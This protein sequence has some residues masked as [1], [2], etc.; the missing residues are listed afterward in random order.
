MLAVFAL[1]LPS[2]A[3]ADTSSVFNINGLLDQGTISGTLSIDPTTGTVTGENF[4]AD[5]YAFTNADL[6]LQGIYDVDQGEQPVYYATLLN[7][8]DIAFKFFFTDATLIGYQGG[9][10][11]TSNDPCQGS[12]ASFFGIGNGQDFLNTGSLQLAVAPSTSV[13]PEPSA[14]LLLGTGLL[15]GT[16]AVRRRRRA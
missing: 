6:S 9:L 2:V 3:L 8:D 4:V 1:A 11:C 15:A 12:E 13:T 10:L 7:P 16:E 14:F 5:G